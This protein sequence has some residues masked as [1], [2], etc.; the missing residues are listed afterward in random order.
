MAATAVGVVGLG[1]LGHAVASRLI[2]AGYRVVGHDVVRERLDAL[3][4]LGGEAVESVAAAVAGTDI[5][6]T[7]LPTL[8]AVEAVILGA[9]GI[10]G[11]ARP[12]TTVVQMSTISPTLTERLAGEVTARGLGF[13]DC[14]VSGTSGMVERGNGVIFV[15]GERVAL[16]PLGARAR[17]G[18]A[19]P[20]LH[21]ARRP[22]DDAEA[23]RQPPR[24]APL[25]G[26]RRG[27]HHGARGPASTSASCSTSSAPAPR[28]RAC[29]KSAAR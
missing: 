17:G 12:G 22:G 2:A 21:R 25:R 28:P 11:A 19:A 6:C 14:P 26:G 10:V 20:R 13:L 15:G 8:D 9:D 3:Q 7:L 29:S 4:A 1:L 18:A 5:V 27:A 24:R 23:R 16:R